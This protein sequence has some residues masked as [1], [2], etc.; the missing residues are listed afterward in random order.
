M[1]LRLNK[2]MA[3]LV[4]AGGAVALVGCGGGDAPDLLPTK[5]DVSIAPGSSNTLAKN[6]I[7][8]LNGEALPLSTAAV[9]NMGLPAGT[10]TLTFTGP[11][12]GT[13]AVGAATIV[14]G[15]K[16][17]TTNVTAGSCVFEVTGPAAEA[18]RIVNPATGVAYKID[19]PATTTVNEADKITVN[20]CSIT[21]DVSDL[22][23]GQ[24]G[25]RSVTITLGTSGTV[26]STVK[27]ERKADGTLL[28]NDKPV[29]NVSATGGISVN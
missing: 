10:T 13:G 24:T 16:S 8:A 5:I 12:T 26:T 2:L 29:A 17:L 1:K 28:M 14:S 4:M 22:Q 25:T 6:V 20:P 11:G 15:T 21:S 9:A 3:G 27:V 7:S 23:P 19:N 18:D